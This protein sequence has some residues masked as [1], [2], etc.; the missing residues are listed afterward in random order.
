METM[1]DIES[2]MKAIEVQKEAVIEHRETHT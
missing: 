1:E 2:M